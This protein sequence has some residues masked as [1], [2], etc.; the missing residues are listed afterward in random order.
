MLK[1]EVVQTWNRWVYYL[2]KIKFLSYILE[3]KDYEFTRIKPFLQRLVII[4]KPLRHFFGS[5][6]TFLL[7]RFLSQSMYKLFDLNHPNLYASLVMML[8][9]STSLTYHF[10]L[11]ATQSMY[12]YYTVFR[13]P[14]NLVA[15][16]SLFI[17]RILR[18]L[19]RTIVLVVL[20]TE[21]SRFEA[22]VLS[23]LYLALSSIS[24]SIFLWI[25]QKYRKDYSQ[26]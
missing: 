7:V 22:I 24:E 1:S 26:N 12:F 18:Y 5:V 8:F 13:F 11:K 2:C 25:F 4:L 9:L 6:I 20:F 14:P 21:I 17:D 15:K 16:A 10:V 23:T 3:P 19:V